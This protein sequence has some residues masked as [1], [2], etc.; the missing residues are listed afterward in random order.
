MSPKCSQMVKPPITLNID[1]YP[2]QFSFIADKIGHSEACSLLWHLPSLEIRRIP[3]K[4]SEVMK[5]VTIQ[6][7]YNGGNAASLAVRLNITYKKIS[8]IVKTIHD[9]ILIVDTECNEEMAIIS[10]MCGQS[11]SY[12]LLK[13]F[14]GHCIQIPK[15][16]RYAMIKKLIKKEFNG[17]NHKQIAVEYNVGVSYVYKVLKEDMKTINNSKQTDLFK[18]I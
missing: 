2:E 8:K 7:E 4:P 1:E 10:E 9:E 15:S 12:K 14:P 5:L 6:N 11:V 17:S 3:S 16:G 18:G 13:H